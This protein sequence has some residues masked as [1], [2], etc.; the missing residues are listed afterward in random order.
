ME[1][2]NQ[3]LQMLYGVPYVGPVAGAVLGLVLPISAL[4]TAVV[5]LWHGLVMLASA[6]ALIPGLQKMQG[7]ATWLQTEDAVVQGVM[8]KWVK[9]V[10]DR[11][12][13]LPLP[14][15]KQ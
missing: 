13:L 3:L 8:A 14:T 9:P 11:L 12:S 1:M 4:M 5:A 10:V 15:V 2:V 7:V 6:L